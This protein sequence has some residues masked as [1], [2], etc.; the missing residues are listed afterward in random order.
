[1]K[2]KEYLKDKT[3]LLL[4]HIVCMF[5]LVSFLSLTGYPFDSCAV[6]LVCWGVVL[7]GW[8]TQQFLSRRHYFQ[9]LKTYYRKF[10]SEVFTGGTHAEISAFGRQ[11]VPHVDSEI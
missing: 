3:L 7:G 6:I 4:L 2:I 1:M 11:T 8:L 5:L 10:G 9:E